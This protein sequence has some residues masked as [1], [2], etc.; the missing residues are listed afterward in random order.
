MKQLAIISQEEND[1]ER[2]LS[3][4]VECLAN[5]GAW[6]YATR[7]GRGY[8]VIWADDHH[9][10]DRATQLLRDSGFDAAPLTYNYSQQIRTLAPPANVS[11]QNSRGQA[12]CQNSTHAGVAEH[13]RDIQSC[14]QCWWAR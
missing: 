10:P 1:I 7:R 14:G 2:T 8:A 11:N 6:V 4:C 9:L 13:M 5:A 12:S 3:D